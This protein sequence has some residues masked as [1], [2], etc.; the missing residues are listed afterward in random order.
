MQMHQSLPDP[1]QFKS[2]R[3]LAFIK[4]TILPKHFYIVNVSI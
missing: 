3:K 2:N 1:I 4:F